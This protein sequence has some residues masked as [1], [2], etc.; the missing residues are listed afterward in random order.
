MERNNI[1][2][3]QNNLQLK[4]YWLK[5]MEGDLD[6]KNYEFPLAK[7]KRIIKSDPNVTMLASEVPLLFS[8]A[9]KMFIMDLT[10]RAWRHTQ[11]GNRI[12]IYKSDIAAA[13]ARTFTMDFLLDVVNAEEPVAAIS[14]YVAMPYHNNDVLPP[15]M[16]IGTPVVDG[17]GIYGDVLQP[18][19]GAWN[20]APSEGREGEDAVGG[21]NIH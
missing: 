20:M 1:Q 9:I 17:T 14:N 16:V 13:V 19:P 10:M 2:P 21:N 11:E 4:S 7:I 12:T 5:E 18:W 6:F 3:P 8:K 15:G